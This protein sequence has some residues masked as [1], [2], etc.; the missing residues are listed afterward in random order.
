[1]L[2]YIL[3]LLPCRI[4][5]WQIYHSISFSQTIFLKNNIFYPNF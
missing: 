3:R 1:L 4:K 5:R 2:P